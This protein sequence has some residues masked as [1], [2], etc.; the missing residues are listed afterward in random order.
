MKEKGFVN[1]LFLIILLIGLAVG[2]YLVQN[3]TIFKSFAN[4]NPIVFKDQSGNP[5]AENNGIPYTSSPSLKIVLTSILGPPSLLK[6]ITSKLPITKQKPTVK[7][8]STTQTVA[9]QPGWNSFGLTVNTGSAN[10]SDLLVYLNNALAS[11]TNKPNKPK[12]QGTGVLTRLGRYNQSTDNF[13][14][15]VGGVNTAA[16]LKNNFSIQAGEGYLL[17]STQKVTL[18]FTGTL[19]PQQSS[20]KLS[21][22]GNF[23][24]FVSVPDS[25]NTAEKL[26]QSIKSQGGNPSAIIQWDQGG[27]VVHLAGQNDA[28][29]F[30]ILPGKGYSI[31]MDN[32]LNY[33]LPTSTP[34]PTPS[35][36]FTT[37]YKLA[38]NPTD[39][40]TT[41]AVPYITEPTTVDYTLKDTSVG[42]HFIYVRFT[43][44]NGKTDDRSQEVDIVSQSKDVKVLILKY[45]PLDS[46]GQNLDKTI[47]GNGDPLSTV[48]SWVDQQT[49][50][51]LTNLTNGT[52][53]HGYKDSNAQ[54]SLNYKIIDTK[55]FDK[56]APLVTSPPSYH[57]ILTPIDQSPTPNATGSTDITLVSGSNTNRFLKYTISGSLSGLPT[58][59]HLF[60]GNCSPYNG[61]VSCTSNALTADQNGNVNFSNLLSSINVPQDISSWYSQIRV[62]GMSNDYTKIYYY[63][64][65]DI[66][67]WANSTINSINGIYNS[68]LI[69]YSQILNSDANICDYVDNKGVREVWIW[70]YQT[71]KS[72]IFEFMPIPGSNYASQI[73]NFGW[74]N[75]SNCKSTYYA[76]TFNYGGY[77]GTPDMIHS[78]SHLIESIM[79]YIDSSLWNNFVAPFGRTDVTNHCGTVHNPPNNSSGIGTNPL[80]SSNDCAYNYRSETNANSNCEDWHPDGSGT[81]K[82]VNCHNW[83]GQNQSCSDDGGLTYY[84]W[85]MQNIPTNW[86]NFMADFD[87]AI[88]KGKSLY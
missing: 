3:K 29:N 17:Y 44:S 47:T 23:V 20:I 77:R 74:P 34:S 30:N 54:A 81:V 69:D 75:L 9:L 62:Y 35:A 1:I 83:F 36:P 67:N 28:Y 40:N 13:Q 5:L 84:V 78:H 32:D 79:R 8:V 39:L 43:D 63:L 46:S 26:A 11:S 21:S 82:V 64:S 15:Y 70:A 25:I 72:G 31:R 22:G 33:L 45:F 71:D 27:W 52:K 65:T 87:S 55:E 24:S 38:E 58:D 56:P 48:R 57:V 10:A 80:C 88:A 12:T 53:Y 61:S 50:N 37:F 49:Q 73:P 14:T 59:V 76:L 60:I 42:K 19:L 51:A 2:V 66:T 7:D 85:W 68:Q 6:N 4:Q 18:S 16:N 41:P 86:W